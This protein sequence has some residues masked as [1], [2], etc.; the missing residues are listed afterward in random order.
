MRIPSDNVSTS[1]ELLER[2]VADTEVVGIDEGQFFDQQLVD[3]A[4]MLAL[5][6]KRVI[7][8]GLDQD[9]RDAVVRVLEGQDAQLVLLVVERP[10][11]DRYRL[12]CCCGADQTVFPDRSVQ[13][14]VAHHAIAIAQQ[15]NEEIEN[16][17]LDRYGVTVLTQLEGREVDLEILER[18]FCLGIA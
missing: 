15:V 2:V 18:V 8:A 12:A 1:R 5:Q 13:L 14:A 9:V 17:R 11:Q 10:A 4:N 16:E 6:G 3:A 7:V